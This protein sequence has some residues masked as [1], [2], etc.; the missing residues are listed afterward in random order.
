[1]ARL[2]SVLALHGASLAR[3][4]LQYGAR[5]SAPEGDR[6]FIILVPNAHVR[7]LEVTS[8]AFLRFVFR[9]LRLP[10][11]LHIGQGVGRW[12]FWLPSLPAS[13]P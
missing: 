2:C 3:R 12:P 13:K 5:R 9:Y 8:P 6:T 11:L 10:V 7:G 4:R 1:M